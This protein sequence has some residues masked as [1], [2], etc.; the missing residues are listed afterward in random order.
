MT[1]FSPNSSVAGFIAPTDNFLEGKELDR[2]LH[3]FLLGLTSVDPSLIRPR[4]QQE[5]ANIPDI[6]TAWLAF[7]IIDRKDDTNSIQV[8]KNTFMEVHR[9][10][11]LDILISFYGD[12]GSLYEAN[13]RDGLDIEQNR[14][15]LR[16][17]G[18]SVINCTN[19]INTSVEINKRWLKR[20]DVHLFLRRHIV[21]NYPILDLT[22]ASFDVNG[23]LVTVNQ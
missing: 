4:W 6:D 20:M 21:R 14:V 16:S 11:E 19:P 2:F 3:D 22:S 8:F 5:P 13:L 7:G 15:Y 17:Q 12:S 10:Q 23:D 18:M 9:Y 1:N